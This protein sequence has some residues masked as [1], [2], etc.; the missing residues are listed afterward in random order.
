[1]KSLVAAKF[2]YV[3]RRCSVS[4]APDLLDNSAIKFS[5]V[6]YFHAFLFML[7]HSMSTPVSLK[8]IHVLLNETC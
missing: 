2:V 6:L 8:K 7:M 3:Y 1:M 4:E 5:Q